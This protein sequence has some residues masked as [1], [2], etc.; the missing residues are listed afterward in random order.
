MFIVSKHLLLGQDSN[1][2]DVANNKG[3]YD[4][5]VIKISNTGDL[6]W[7]KSFGGSEIDE[8]RAISNTADGNYLVV[9]DT[10]SANIDVSQNR[11]AA[12]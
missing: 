8:A 1:D 9:G 11:G 5:W 4:F 2:V 6:V 10:R 12:D 7:E 3:S